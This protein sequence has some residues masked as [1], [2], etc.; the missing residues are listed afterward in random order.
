[1]CV[2][3]WQQLEGYVSDLVSVPSASPIVQIA[4]VKKVLRFCQ[5]GEV[6]DS[7]FFEALGTQLASLFKTTYVLLKVSVL[8]LA[9]FT[10]SLYLQCR[11]V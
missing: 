1:M 5:S 10:D 8:T 7:A 2:C 4:V 9:S 11:V 3:V 6:S